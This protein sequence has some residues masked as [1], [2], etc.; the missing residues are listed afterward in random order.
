M[1]GDLVDLLRVT[2]GLSVVQSVLIAPHDVPPYHGFGLAYELAIFLVEG[3]LHNAVVELNDHH[4]G[5]IAANGLGDQVS[6][7]DLVTV[8]ALSR[9]QCLR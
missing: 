4:E 6:L 1:H 8:E 9:N 7:L 2:C 3:A 5:D